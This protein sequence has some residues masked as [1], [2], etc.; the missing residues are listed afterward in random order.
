[1]K[2]ARSVER[3]YMQYMNKLQSAMKPIPD[4]VDEELGSSL[5]K[6]SDTTFENSRRVIRLLCELYGEHPNV[7]AKFCVTIDG[8]FQIILSN[9]ANNGLVTVDDHGIRLHNSYERTHKYISVSY[10]DDQIIG[11][12]RKYMKRYI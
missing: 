11:Q 7:G 10:A 12:F 9:G 6:P 4:Y 2:L 3:Q 8:K 1:M 5:K